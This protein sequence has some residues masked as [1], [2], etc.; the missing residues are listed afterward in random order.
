LSHGSQL[1][2]TKDELFTA[3]RRGLPARVQPPKR[4]FV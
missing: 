1:K 3:R 2:T 4:F